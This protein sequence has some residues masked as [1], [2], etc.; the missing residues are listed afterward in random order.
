MRPADLDAVSS[1]SSPLL[2]SLAGLRSAPEL[3][4]EQRS[5][6]LEDLAAALSGCEW[7]TIGVM[8]ASPAAA[9]TALRDCETWCGWQPLLPA[10][11]SLDSALEEGPVFLKGN[12]RTGTYLVRREDGLGDGVLITGHN[13]ADPSPEGTWGPLPLDL[14]PRS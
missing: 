4:A 14:F 11:G 10:A 3:D 6:L 5:L 9:V 12:Q 1:P 2:S 13:P 8:A 7:F